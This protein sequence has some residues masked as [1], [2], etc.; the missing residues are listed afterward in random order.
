MWLIKLRTFLKSLLFHVWAGFPKS[1]QSEIES[2]YITCALCEN[3]NQ[4]KQE[5]GICGCSVNRKRI[6]LNKLAWAD[7]ECP[8]GKWTKIKR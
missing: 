7:Q 1:T 5:C 2:R 6:F 3:F 4:Q 8:V